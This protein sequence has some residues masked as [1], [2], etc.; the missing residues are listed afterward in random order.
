MVSVTSTE[1]LLV[2]VQQTARASCISELLVTLNLL[3][4]TCELQV[5]LTVT[6]QPQFHSIT[7]HQ[8]NS[9]FPTEQLTR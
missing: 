1:G 2:P 8:F 3:F 5:I 9:K 6:V 4:T 7:G